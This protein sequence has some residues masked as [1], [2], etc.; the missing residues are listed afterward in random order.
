MLGSRLDF[1]LALVCRNIT[2]SEIYITKTNK[3]TNDKMIVHVS[4]LQQ[5]ARLAKKV[6]KTW[7][8]L[9]NSLQSAKQSEEIPMNK[10]YWA[11]CEIESSLSHKVEELLREK[12]RLLTIR[13][14]QLRHGYDVPSYTDGLD[15]RIETI[16]EIL[17][18]VANKRNNLAEQE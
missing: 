3:D 4:W 13:M 6:E 10:G 5:Q 11:L 15:I 8:R 12:N 16:Q 14:E 9:G 1:C 18:M 7:K 2:Q 17:I